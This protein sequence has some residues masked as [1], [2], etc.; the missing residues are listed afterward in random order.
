MA[1]FKAVFDA[2]D[3]PAAALL[4]E[5]LDPLRPG[6]AWAESLYSHPLPAA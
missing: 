6:V 3:T 4:H 2:V 1:R 5:H